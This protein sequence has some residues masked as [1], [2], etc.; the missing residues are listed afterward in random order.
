MMRSPILP[1]ADSSQGRPSC[2]LR[3]QQEEGVILD[4]QIAEK[5]RRLGYGG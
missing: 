5:L 4:Q 3:Q 2:Q 1:L